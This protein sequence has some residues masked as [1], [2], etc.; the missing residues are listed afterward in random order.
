MYCFNLRVKKSPPSNKF[1]L[2]IRV[3]HR[4]TAFLRNL[5]LEYVKLY[6]AVVVINCFQKE[7][8]TES[9]NII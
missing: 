6:I 8:V 2:L 5:V 4:N 3:A 7:T 9:C 1:L